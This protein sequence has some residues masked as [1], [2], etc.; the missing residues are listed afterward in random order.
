LRTRTLPFGEGTN[1]RFD[2]HFL[3]KA[4]AFLI[5]L[6]AFVS[7][8]LVLIKVIMTEARQLFR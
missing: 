8:L 7:L 5:E 6:A 2:R 3:S 1:V 4:K